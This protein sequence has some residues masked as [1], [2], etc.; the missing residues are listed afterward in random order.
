MFGGDVYFPPLGTDFCDAADYEVTNLGFVSERKT[1]T[2]TRG[3]G[4]EGG[5]GMWGV[6]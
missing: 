6:P 5:M 2:K 4:K 3:D 1:G